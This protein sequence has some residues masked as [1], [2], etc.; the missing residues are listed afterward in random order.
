LV[1]PCWVLA[2]ASDGVGLT[3]IPMLKSKW[4]DVSRSTKGMDFD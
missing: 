1:I 2:A 3:P 4:R